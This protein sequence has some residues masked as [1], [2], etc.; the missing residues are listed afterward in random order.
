MHIFHE[1]SK[2]TAVVLLRKAFTSHKVPRAFSFLEAI[3]RKG[4]NSERLFSSAGVESINPS[5]F[6]LQNVQCSPLALPQLGA[7]NTQAFPFSLLHVGF[8]TNCCKV[9]RYIH[10]QVASVC[11]C[12]LPFFLDCVSFATPEVHCRSWRVT[13]LPGYTNLINI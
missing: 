3:G 9:A 5:L 12:R 2:L 8:C 4:G 11:V 13:L 6:I 10:H 1:A 7:E